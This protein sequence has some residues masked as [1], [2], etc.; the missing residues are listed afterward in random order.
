MEGWLSRGGYQGQCENTEC[1][2]GTSLS[3]VAR[4]I[5]LQPTTTGETASF[6]GDSGARAMDG[7]SGAVD[8]ER[9]CG[10]WCNAAD[11]TTDRAAR[12]NDSSEKVI[13][14]WLS[15]GADRPKTL[16]P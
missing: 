11:T 5:M 12:K 8:A 1:C 2:S 7:D 16:A 15:N 13:R 6:R 4:P 3:A 10:G 9:M 14:K